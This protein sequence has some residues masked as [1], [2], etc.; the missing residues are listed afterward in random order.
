MKKILSAILVFVML[1]PSVMAAD[2][3]DIA[4]SK[5]KDNITLL[6]NLGIVE[7]DDSGNYNPNNTISRIEFFTII[8]RM[9]MP[10]MMYTAKPEYAFVDVP[11]NHWAYNYACFM[12]EIGLVDGVGDDKLLPDAPISLND[13]CKVII[14]ALDR[15]YEAEYIGGYPNGYMT[16][17]RDLE[18]YR[19]GFSPV[20]SDALTRE[21]VAYLISNSLNIETGVNNEYD[22][23]TFLDMRQIEIR[24]GI[25]DS[26]FEIQTNGNL[27][28]NQIMIDSKVY[29]KSIKLGTNTPEELFGATVIIY[30][31]KDMD[32]IYHITRKTG[33]TSLQLD[34]KAIVSADLT[35][36]EY[37]LDGLKNK[38]AKLLNPQVVKNGQVLTSGQVNTP[39]ALI[40]RPGEVYLID[41]DRDKQY[42]LVNIYEYSTYVVKNCTGDKIYDKFGR[43]FDISNSNEVVVYYDGYK[44]DKSF[45]ESGDVLSIRKDDAQR[46]YHI[47]ITR[48]KIYGE[49]ESKKNDP[50]YDKY[51]ISGT[52]YCIND[53][54]K[55]Y[56]NANS[57]YAVELKIGL[58][59]TYYLDKFG[60]VAFVD[61]IAEDGEEIPE[62]DDG[63]K[64]GYLMDV[65]L[66]EEDTGTV[67][68]LDVLTENNK[69]ETFKI[70][71][72]IKFGRESNGQYVKSKEGV[73]AIEQVL[74]NHCG[75][76]I[77]Y[78]LDENEYI[79]AEIYVSGSRNDRNN[80]SLDL[81]GSLDYRAKIIEDRYYVDMNTVCFHIPFAG[82][83]PEYFRAGRYNEILKTGSQN[84]R[85]YDIDVDGH[86]GAIISSA[87]SIT[88]YTESKGEYEVLV[89]PTNSSIMYVTD[90]Y[91]ML[92]ENDEVAEFMEGYQ[93]GKLTTVRIGEGVN[94]NSESLDIIKPG[95]VVQY[96]TNSTELTRAETSE[97]ASRIVVIKEVTDLTA[98]NPSGI[99]Y[100]YADMLT[101]RVGATESIEGLVR[102]H[103]KIK[104]ISPAT[105]TLTTT[106]RLIV[107]NPNIVVMAYNK[108][109]NEITV[110]SLD[111]LEV[112]MKIFCRMRNN[113]TIEIVYYV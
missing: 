46:I 30:V 70:N 79:I 1:I 39:G 91:T 84:M 7:G 95:A 56:E 33:G 65:R 87:N 25:V 13:A 110:K 8:L 12:R 22:G 10:N 42:D 20:N 99:Q 37:S 74:Q 113:N 59:A 85:L 17:A 36:Y 47:F 44:V 104:Y 98:N 3:S 43:S 78:A 68:V 48:E 2:M 55:Q 111:D 94:K 28:E 112:G 54:Y 38:T 31:D 100:S 107:K 26:V 53:I 50:D 5:Y 86:V 66:A 80:L 72:K 35:K 52:T 67:A 29:N 63:L 73:T 40:P 77:T 61:F 88:R 4:E 49:I 41:T 96:V 71:D 69:F 92:D 62:A 82:A 6:Y 102:I 16:V 109:E 57:P 51:V 11:E 83:Y 105:I 18:I 81:S 75:K 45:I 106:N 19:K 58:N 101:T 97:N 90:R 93:N 24:E 108:R 64:Y 76:L 34:G 27:T 32:T 103:D 23:P 21:E 15:E 89:D 14:T 9:K 60:D